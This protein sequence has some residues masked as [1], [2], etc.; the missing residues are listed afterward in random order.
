VAGCYMSSP[1]IS[2]TIG[3]MRLTRS[4]SQ[5]VGNQV[6]ACQPVVLRE[7][8][9]YVDLGWAL[10]SSPVLCRSGSR[11]PRSPNA[12]V[13]LVVLAASVRCYCHALV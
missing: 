3:V 2:G 8:M 5:H 10:G 1:S 13:V 9:A 7:R 4:A 6:W 11:V 12:P